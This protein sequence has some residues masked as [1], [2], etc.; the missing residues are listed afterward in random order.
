MAHWAI[1]RT[2][3]LGGVAE[4]TVC[5]GWWKGPRQGI[6]WQSGDHGVI[7]LGATQQ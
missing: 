1:W 2:E 3:F 6:L 4:N 5:P 7:A